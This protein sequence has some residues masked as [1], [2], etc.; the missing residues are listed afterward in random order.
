MYKVNKVNK[1]NIPVFKRLPN[2]IGVIPDGNRR[3]AERNGM[4]KECGYEH[5][6]IPG[7]KLYNLCHA[8]GIK[9]LT[10][11][12]FTQDNTKRPDSQ[13]KAFKQACVDAVKSLAEC[14]ASL[15]VIGNAESA[16]F[17]RELIPYT[18]RVSFGRG[19]I[20][21]NFLVNYGWQWDLK[22]GLSQSGKAGKKSSVHKYLASYDVSRLDLIIRWGGRRRLSGFLPV[23]SIY[24]DFYII[25]EYWP[26]FIPEHLYEALRWYE[27][28]DITLGG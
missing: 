24:S 12:G 10:F 11:Y 19:S 15:R 26:D 20:K 27:I 16:S 2:H 6:I 1:V 21:I 17:P 28:Q 4:T 25:D 3:W 18:N 22:Y 13:K 5:G 8:L 9:E 7:L 14:D 23:Q